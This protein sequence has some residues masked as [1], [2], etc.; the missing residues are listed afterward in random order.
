MRP[1]I[2]SNLLLAQA[3][4]CVLALTG[5]TLA[6][7]IAE[8]KMREQTLQR[9]YRSLQVLTRCNA[10]VVHAVEER[11]LLQ[12]VCRVAVD[13]AGYHLACVGYGENDEA[14]TSGPSPMPAR[15]KVPEPRSRELGRQRIRPR[16]LGHRP[17]APAKPA[18]AHDLLHNPDLPTW[19]D[20]LVESGFRSAAAVPLEAHGTSY[21]AI[22]FYT[23]EPYAFGE[24]E[25]EL[26]VELGTNLAHG[27]LTLR[28]E[29]A[30]ADAGG[31]GPAEPRT[32]G[33]G[34]RQRQA[35]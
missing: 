11:Q 3:F 6:A 32:G 29:A 16:H 2:H 23:A 26:L 10:A 15:P 7:A 31:A 9:M 21:G 18:V 22:A 17:S 25:L 28:P 35:V 33:A 19:H 13:T 27:I 30:G 34:Q 1:S 5:N 12:D 14:K 24:S 4:A 20:L 8:R